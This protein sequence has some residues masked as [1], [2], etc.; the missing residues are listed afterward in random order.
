MLVNDNDNEFCILAPCWA[1]YPDLEIKPHQGLN[2][3]PTRQSLSLLNL[4]VSQFATVLG[5]G[6]LCPDL[7]CTFIFMCALLCLH[8]QT[9]AAAQ[10]LLR[11]VMPNGWFWQWKFGWV[12]N[13]IAGSSSS[14]HPW[15][16]DCHK[17][18][19][20]WGTLT[21]G[22][23]NVFLHISYFYFSHSDTML[24]FQLCCREEGE[25]GV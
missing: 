2:F 23:S 20:K 24:K 5:P 1:K 16:R 22:E 15:T 11:D 25:R 18:T 19:Q 12:R 17:G 7:T 13:I 9:S 21:R 14:N 10:A 3:H 8:P 6:G 4:E